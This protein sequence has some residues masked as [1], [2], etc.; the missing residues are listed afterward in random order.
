MLNF[1]VLFFAK[2]GRTEI[3][4]YGQQPSAHRLWGGYEPPVRIH[5]HNVINSGRMRF[6]PTG[7]DCCLRDADGVF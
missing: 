3:R 7:K 4:P 1:S 6:S 2:N 5:Q